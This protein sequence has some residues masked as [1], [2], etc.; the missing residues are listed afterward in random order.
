MRIAILYDGLFPLDIG[1]IE[2]WYLLLA[3]RLAAGGASVSYLT[4]KNWDVAPQV[5]GITVIPISGGRE[6]YRVDGTRKFLQPVRFGWGAVRWLIRH[7]RDFDAIHTANFPNFSLLAA[8]LALFGTGT[9]V[10][11]DWFEVWSRKFCREYAGTLA[12]TI[13]YVIQ[14]LSI[15]LTLHAF[16][17]WNNT[18]ERLRGEGFRNQLTVL[19]G[20]FPAMSA[21]SSGPVFS[22]NY[23]PPYVFF[24]GRHIRDKGIRLL[25]DALATA[26]NQ[27]PNLR[28]VMAGDGPERP[29]IESMARERGLEEFMVFVGKV[30]DDQLRVLAR[31]VC[32]AVISSIREGYGLAVVEAAAQGTPSVVANNPENA[33]TEHIVEGVNGFVVDP[34]PAGL[35]NGFIKAA[36]AGASLRESTYEWY[37]DS[38]RSMT[39]ELSASE[40]VSIYAS[41]RPRILTDRA[42]TFACSSEGGRDYLGH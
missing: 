9:P 31:N 36:T 16:V 39:M 5:P 11:V 6:R 23:E 15:D 12:G 14:K 28:L 22:R 17:F 13:G 18:A 8:R 26:R 35:A 33:A 4:R 34:T 25:P 20:L 1:G 7:R 19:P 30:P 32:C 10:V 24:A 3:Q 21:E 38:A 41:S 37:T 40:V 42:T 27:I 2:R 29:L